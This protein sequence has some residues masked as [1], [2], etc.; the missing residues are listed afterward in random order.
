[1]EPF[2]VRPNRWNYIFPI[3]FLAIGII[4][5]IIFTLH[6]YYNFIDTG[7]YVLGIP[8]LIVLSFVSK[9]FKKRKSYFIRN[10]T[11]TILENKSSETG[12][13]LFLRD[14]VN[15][16]IAEESKD[17][18]KNEI[19]YLYFKNFQIVVDNSEY[20]NY[21]KLKGYILTIVPEDRRIQRVE[22]KSSSIR[23]IMSV[24]NF[25]LLGCV[26]LS[27]SNG[28]F[29][30]RFNFYKIK[31]KDKG[32]SFVLTSILT[33]TPIIADD[34]DGTNIQFLTDST[35]DYVVDITVKTKDE[36][37]IDFIKEF[38][39]AGDTVTFRIH[40]YPYKYFILGEKM[41]SLQKYFIEEKIQATSIEVDNLELHSK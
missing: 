14:L 27:L 28:R 41:S 25:I 12:I 32:K 37:N 13:Q 35:K 23:S 34:E 9:S 2:Y 18:G 4:F 26:F 38:W 24:L 19:L 21:E 15:Y 6:N 22:I 31:G 3:F 39:V 16:Q 36:G 17:D 20:S 1:M 10:D 5:A 29:L 30:G 8:L 33:E 7:I 11:I 40:E